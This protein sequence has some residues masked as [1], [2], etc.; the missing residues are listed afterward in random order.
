MT[1][2]VSAGFAHIN[3]SFEVF[4]EVQDLRE[5]EWITVE[6]IKVDSNHFKSTTIWVG[7]RVIISEERKVTTS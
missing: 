6:K 2:S 5:G 1:T 7:R 4:H 3:E